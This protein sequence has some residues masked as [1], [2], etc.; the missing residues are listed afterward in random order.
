MLG[1]RIP[2]RRLTVRDGATA[3]TERPRMADVRIRR[4]PT[5]SPFDKEDD[6]FEP[7]APGVARLGIV[8]VNVF[9]LG[10]PGG[11]WLR[12]GTRHRRTLATCSHEVSKTAGRRPAEHQVCDAT[13]GYG[14]HEYR[15]LG[16]GKSVVA[17]A[18]LL[19]GRLRKLHAPWRTLAGNPWR[20]R[21]GLARP[22]LALHHAAKPGQCVHQ[23][24][25]AC[26]RPARAEL[27]LPL[28]PRGARRAPVRLAGLSYPCIVCT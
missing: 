19:D 8:F 24:P 20:T 15:T 4:E 25:C 10:E 2:N 21:T 7:V 27:C 3:Q 6:V 14:D 28:L 23:N 17:R 13:E 1:S 16:A 26:L 12:S 5:A 18:N 11:P 9:T 22:S